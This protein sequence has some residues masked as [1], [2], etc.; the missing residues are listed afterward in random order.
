MKKIKILHL[1]QSDRVSGAENLASQII[2]IFSRKNYEIG[3]CSQDGSIRD[4]LKKNGINFYPLKYL[5]FFNFLKVY[6]IFKPDIIHAHDIRASVLASFFSSSSRVISH[7]HGNDL[8]MRVLSIKSIMFFISSFRLDKIIWVSNSALNEYFFFKYVNVKSVVMQNILLDCKIKEDLYEFNSINQD[9]DV[10]YIGRLSYPKD[11]IRL[12]NILIAVS[13]SI[14][15]I[16]IAIIG[17]G[18]FFETL[19]KIIKNN[20]VENNIKLMG[21]LENPLDILKKSKVLVLTSIFEGTPMVA[22]EAMSLGIPIVSTPTD[23][24]V[25][26]IDHGVTGYLSKSDDDLINYIIQIVINSDLFVKLS[27]NTLYRYKIINDINSYI[28]GLENIYNK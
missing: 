5:N 18:D 12:I 23:G 9:F 7:I 17:Q 28:E 4:Y 26:L 22:L 6:R 16:K 2:S 11:P 1:L 21:F 24:L 27:T 14:P 3:Y 15:D 13:K 25:E 8:K 10:V 19:K 20:N